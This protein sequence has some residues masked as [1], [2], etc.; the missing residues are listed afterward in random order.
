MAFARPTLTDLIS[1]IESDYISRLTGGGSLLRR[2]VVKVLA[3]VH[4]GAMHLLYGFA[5]WISK[6]VIPDTAEAE[7]LARWAKIW[8]IL[9]KAATYAEFNVEFSGVNGTLIPE[10]TELSSVDGLLYETQ[11]DG[12]ISGGVIVVSVIAREAGT[13][14]NVSTDQELSLSSPI[15]GVE[16]VATVESSGNVDGTDTE[17]D[18][19]LLE[20]LLGRIQEPPH[21][22][23]ENDYETWAKEVAGVTRAWCLPLY[24][25]AGTVG[26]T[27]V[28]DDDVSIIP[29]G[30]E[31]TEVQEYIDEL[32]PVTADLTVFAPTAVPLDFEIDLV[33]D[34]DVQAAIEAELEDLILR[35]AEPGGTILLSHIQE[36]ISKAAG[37]TD[38][39]LNDPAANVTVTAGQLSTMG[40]VTWV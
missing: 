9:R 35:E 10:G 8:G 21:G 15:A 19:D 6:Q 13:D 1:R 40:T 22:G 24:L 34:P 32:R 20:R 39:I 16:S 36:A 37:E 17:E 3:R 14:S 28:R 2:S 7:N 4:A 30:G 27:F 26:L 31:V 5:F 11:A 33:S 38:H 18:E 12:T 23:N 29:S 25:G